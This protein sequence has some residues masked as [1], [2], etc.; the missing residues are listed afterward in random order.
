VNIKLRGYRLRNLFLV[1]SLLILSAPEYIRGV[2]DAF[3]NRL[4]DFFMVTSK[5]AKR[6]FGWRKLLSLPQFL[7]CGD[8]LHHRSYHDSP[9]SS[10]PSNYV[11]WIILF[12]IFVN[13][14]CLSHLFLFYGDETPTSVA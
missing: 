1:Q 8:F 6:I 3:L 13:C 5:T 7:Y 11:M 10:N 9:S 2:G 4:P 12:W 14:L